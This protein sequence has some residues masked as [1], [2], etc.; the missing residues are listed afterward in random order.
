MEQIFSVI[1]LFFIVFINISLSVKQPAKSVD[2]VHDAYTWF[3]K[4]GYNPC[5][6][7]KAQCSTSLKSIIE[8]YQERFRLKKTGELDK[9]TKKHMNRPRCGM[10][11][12]PLAQSSRVASAVLGL[13]WRRP[14]LTYSIQSYP[15]QLNEPTVRRIISDAFQAWTK[16]IPLDIYEVCSTCQSDFKIEFSS[17]SHSDGY[18]FDGVGGTLAH[19]FFPEDGRIHF[20]KDETYTER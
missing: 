2:S 14:S 1:L 8:D 6:K 10:P 5:S 16:H 19:A 20:D 11:D 12:Q 17:G 3:D 4:F 9:E 15:S 13:K 18:P 7:K